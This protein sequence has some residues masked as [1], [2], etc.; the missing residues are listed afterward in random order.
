MPQIIFSAFDEHFPLSIIIWFSHMPQFVA[1]ILSQAYWVRLTAQ[2]LLLS[3]Q[4]MKTSETMGLFT[5]PIPPPT[6]LLLSNSRP[7]PTQSVLLWNNPLNPNSKEFWWTT[8]SPGPA[9]GLVSVYT[10]TCL[11]MTKEAKCPLRVAW[12]PPTRSGLILSWKNSMD[13][14]QKS[15][16]LL[17]L[18]KSP[19]QSWPNPN[20]K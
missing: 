2:A 13:R 18:S 9:R 8:M 3:F 15:L 16:S 5:Q 17:H 7:H 11:K 4:G 6:W 19:L 14:H 10:S 12:W 20:C 1:T